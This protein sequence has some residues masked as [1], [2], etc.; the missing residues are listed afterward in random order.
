MS[1]YFLEANRRKESALIKLGSVDP[2]YYEKV[3]RMAPH[4]PE[5]YYGVPDVGLY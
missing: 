1:K 3:N 4:R 2:W 5:T